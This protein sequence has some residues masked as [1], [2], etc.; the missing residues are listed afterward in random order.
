MGML[1][2]CTSSLAKGRPRPEPFGWIFWGLRVEQ[3]VMQ[4]LFGLDP[5]AV[6]LQGHHFRVRRRDVDQVAIALHVRLTRQYPQIAD[7]DRTDLHVPLASVDLH[8]GVDE[9][10]PAGGNAAQLAV[11][12]PVRTGRQRQHHDRFDRRPFERRLEDD[13]NLGPA[14]EVVAGRRDGATGSTRESEGSFLV[15]DD[16]SQPGAVR[17]DRRIPTT[18]RARRRRPKSGPAAEIGCALSLWHQML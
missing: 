12:K 18:R 2:S 8:R 15:F 17:Q 3:P 14:F 1:V 16:S 11:D 9:V 13:R 4:R 6:V 5:R 10:R 7:E